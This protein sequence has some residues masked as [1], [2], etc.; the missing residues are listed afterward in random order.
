V[1]AL[2]TPALVALSALATGCAQITLGAP[3]ASE[4]GIRAARESGIAASQVGEFKLAAGKPREVDGAL[5]LRGSSLASPYDGSMARYLQQTLETELRAAG[6]LD[7]NA[8]QQI[9]GE[10]LESSIDPAISEGKARLAARFS[11]RRDGR[12]VFAK[13]LVAES[14]WASS[15]VGAVAIPAAVNEY[16]ALHRK[17]VAM[18]L[19]DA[20][21]RRAAVR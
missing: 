21:F 8:K 12:V 17:L 13:E 7:A 4:A 10:L 15:F 1:R 16:G 6:L 20:D 5:S 18:L 11:V 3:T 19:A 14:A 2:L 9:V